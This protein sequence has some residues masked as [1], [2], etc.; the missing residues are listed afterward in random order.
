MRSRRLVPFGILSRYVARQLGKP[1]LIGFSIVT[2]LL[3]LDLI[4]DYLELILGKGIPLWMVLRLFLLGLG[5]MVALSVPCGV[6]VAVLMVYGQMS[7]DSEVTAMKASGVNLFASM[8]PTLGLST[9]LAIS[10]ILFNNHVLPE[11]NHAF[12]NLAAEINRMRPTAQI[13]EGVFTTDFEG[14]D[15][16]IGRLDDRTGKMNDVLIIDASES[17]ATPRTIRSASGFLDVEPGTHAI[18]LR[19]IDGEIH[20]PDPRSKDGRYRR[21]SFR[22][23][24]MVLA[25]SEDAFEKAVRRA[26]G[27]REMS[28][29]QM[30][31]EVGKL[32]QDLSTYQAQVDS[33]ITALGFRSIAEVPAEFRGTGRP[34]TA[35]R[36][37]GGVAALFGGKPGRAGR[38]DTVAT[39][40]VRQQRLEDLRVQVFQAK[41][42]RDRINSFQ[43]EIHKKYSIPIACI[44]FVLTGAP[45]GMRMRRGGLAAGFYSVVFFLFYWACLIAGEELGDRGYVSPWL[46]MWFPNL[47]LGAFGVFLTFRASMSLLPERSAR[48]VRK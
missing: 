38:R 40:P 7:Q 30:R 27:Q 33:A 22:E 45:L 3:T 47:M 21:L 20:E 41:G 8:V 44:V 13:Q 15:L 14:Y 43:V 24:T 6:L 46:A 28:A 26:R 25:G 5:W 9:L 23:Q 17:R 2:F 18:S 1:F 36:L 31:D 16:F 10:L 32:R 37:M 48:R 34:G 19:L 35:A 42:I 29:A 12:A 4:L 11:T 39:D